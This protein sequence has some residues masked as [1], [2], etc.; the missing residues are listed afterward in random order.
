MAEQPDPPVATIPDVIEK[1]K[2]S[3]KFGSGQRYVAPRVS[4]T[5]IAEA[6]ISAGYDRKL[7]ADSLGMTRTHLANRIANNRD[8]KA[9][10]GRKSVGIRNKL[11]IEKLRG[12]GKQHAEIV[13]VIGKQQEELAIGQARIAQI[14]LGRLVQI[15]DRIEKGNEARQLEGI[16]VEMLTD[17]EKKFIYKWRFSINENEDEEK[18]L[19]DQEKAMMQAYSNANESVSGVAWKKAQTEAL[20]RKSGINRPKSDKPRSAPPKGSAPPQVTITDSNV[21]IQQPQPQPQP[22][23]TA[24]AEEKG[25]E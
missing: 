12:E 8:L 2:K 23:I 17:D 21:V 11:D 13:D 4:A 16:P 10:F 1:P 20:L 3:T 15:Q 24:P 5:R 19:F 14:A 7:A 22:Q 25:I 6:I 9:A 18:K